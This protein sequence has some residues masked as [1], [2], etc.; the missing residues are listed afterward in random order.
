MLSSTPKH[1]EWKYKV[2]C[3]NTINEWEE[4]NYDKH[5]EKYIIQDG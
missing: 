5:L 4:K 2:I 1:I 3:Y